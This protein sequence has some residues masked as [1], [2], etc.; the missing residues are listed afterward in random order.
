MSDRVDDPVSDQLNCKVSDNKTHTLGELRKGSK[1]LILRV[2][3]ENQDPG[4]TARLLE[5]GLLEGSMV[6]V[7]HEAPL[8][9]DP[10]AIRV[11]GT[12]IALRRN[13]ANAVEVCIYE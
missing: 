2:G 7:L 11:R 4:M 8:G 9:G 13:E 12:L 1:A 3:T 6:E 5:M 10:M